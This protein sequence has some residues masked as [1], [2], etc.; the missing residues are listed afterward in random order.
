MHH[1]SIS[2]ASTATPTSNYFGY[3]SAMSHCV[4]ASVASSSSLHPNQSIGALSTLPGN[5]SSHPMSTFGLSQF[6]ANLNEYQVLLQNRLM[7]AGFPPLF[8][9]ASVASTLASSLTP[10]TQA[11]IIMSNGSG[12]GTSASNVNNNLLQTLQSLYAAQQNVAVQSA[13]QPNSHPIQTAALATH[14]PATPPAP[15]ASFKVNGSS[16]SGPTPVTTSV[17]TLSTIKSSGSTNFAN[18]HREVNHDKMSKLN[19][20][21]PSSPPTRPTKVA[22]TGNESSIKIETT[23]SPSLSSL[24]NRRKSA[25]ESNGKPSQSEAS[26]ENKSSERKTSKKTKEKSLDSTSDNSN[27]HLVNVDEPV[28]D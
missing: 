10:S 20:C 25:K 24:E 21:S 28:V 27:H 9:P 8:N 19:R 2:A 1:P 22:R 16:L 13:A 18:Y 4:N 11:A 26:K 12:S 23:C 17:T 7:A 3:D 5:I 6:G 15:H 14:Q